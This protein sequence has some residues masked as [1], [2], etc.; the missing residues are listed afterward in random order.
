MR[1]LSVFAL[2]VSAVSF[3]SA[4]TIAFSCIPNNNNAVT[5]GALVGGGATSVTCTGLD[6]GAGSRI[7]N[8]S[9][10]ITYTFQDS[11]NN[12]LHQL[13]YNATSVFG[14]F[15]TGNQNTTSNGAFGGGS[16]TFGGAMSIQSTG[17]NYLVNVVSSNTVNTN[18]LPDNASYTIS[19]V[20]TYEAQTGTPEPS[21]LALVG[22]V[23]VLA[24]LRKF[25]S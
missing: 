13:T 12:G 15:S 19:G 22:G 7:T 25:R 18:V 8:V 10:D 9:Y 4:N 20:Y 6:A 2:L 1:L 14:N 21:T 3:A 5:D 23:L 11:L 16:S 24:G 17:G